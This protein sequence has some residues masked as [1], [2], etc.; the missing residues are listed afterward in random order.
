MKDAIKAITVLTI[1]SAT[2]TGGYDPFSATGIP[3]A[4]QLIR[5]IN[6][7]KGDVGISYDGITT[8]EFLGADAGMQLYFQSN[9][10]PNNKIACLAKGSNVCVIGN[11]NVGFIHF[12]GYYQES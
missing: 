12:I 3:E 5:I 7:S 2:L 6:F 1:D 10:R 9:S 11:A 4:C 8:H